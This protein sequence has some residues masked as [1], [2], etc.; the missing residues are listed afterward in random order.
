RSTP[1]RRASSV[2][3]GVKLPGHCN[4]LGGPN[5]PPFRL[6][7]LAPV[8]I[9]PDQ[10]STYQF[11]RSHGLLSQ[12]LTEASDPSVASAALLQ[13]AKRRHLPFAESAKEGKPSTS[14]SNSPAWCGR[15]TLCGTGR[16]A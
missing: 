7:F 1:G 13:A 16:A 11:T 3:P 14:S 2:K 4:L 9:D 8:K 12:P 10:L 6:P 15:Y 5:G